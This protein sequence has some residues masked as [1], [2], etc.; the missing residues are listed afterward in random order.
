MRQVLSELEGAVDRAGESYA[1]D[2][3][4]DR[5]DTEPAHEPDQ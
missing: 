4:A 1:K 5:A 3:P 2:K